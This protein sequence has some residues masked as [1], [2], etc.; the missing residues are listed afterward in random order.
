MK[1][2]YAGIANVIAKKEISREF[3]QEDASANNIAAELH[4]L[5]D[6]QSYRTAMKNN[7]AK[8]KDILGEKDGSAATADI[9]INF[10]TRK[11]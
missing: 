10:L 6:D 7:M 1:F 4:R 2:S 9:A 11:I 5:L 3:I 8:I